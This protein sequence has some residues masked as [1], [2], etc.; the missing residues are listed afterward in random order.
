M[1]VER[2]RGNDSEDTLKALKVLVLWLRVHR[3]VIFR[4]GVLNTR[5]DHHPLLV[6]AVGIFGGVCIEAHIS[7]RFSLGP[8]VG[9]KT[10]GSVDAVVVGRRLRCTDGKSIVVVTGRVRFC[11]GPAAG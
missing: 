11:A 5:G 9:S 4:D 2:R 10:T 7:A 8:D 1:V 3:T 6:F